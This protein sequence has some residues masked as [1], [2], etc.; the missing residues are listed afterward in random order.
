MGLSATPQSFPGVSQNQSQ[1]N[2][3]LRIHQ[4]QSDRIHSNFPSE[5]KQ[6]L[7]LTVNQIPFHSHDIKIGS[8]LGAG[9][10]FI[11]EGVVRNKGTMHCIDSWEEQ[12]GEASDSFHRFVHINAWRSVT[13]GKNPL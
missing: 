9:T 6:L 13:I 3:Y 2:S 11:A 5:D 8:H 12:E 7:N 1:A 10:C 4:Q